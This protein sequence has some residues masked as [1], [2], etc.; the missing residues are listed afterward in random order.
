[1]VFYSRKNEIDNKISNTFFEY[2]DLLMN[3][4]YETI[5]FAS[6]DQVDQS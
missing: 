3:F 6:Y 1:M 5:I 4:Y 2:E